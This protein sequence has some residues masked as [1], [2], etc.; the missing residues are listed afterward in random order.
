MCVCVC[1]WSVKLVCMLQSTQLCSCRGGAGCRSDPRFR[2]KHLPAEFIRL[3]SSV[4]SK[5][6]GCVWIPAPTHVHPCGPIFFPSIPSDLQGSEFP[7]PRSPVRHRSD[8]L[9][10]ELGD[11]SGCLGR[12]R[13]VKSSDFFLP[14]S[15]SESASP[16]TGVINNLYGD[17]NDS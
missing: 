5:T 15:K 16:I 13:S 11:F 4:D 7:S 6:F 9:C 2:D 1:G 12:Y 8:D 10:S 3:K 14:A 17:I